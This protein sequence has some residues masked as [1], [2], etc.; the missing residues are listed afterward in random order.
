MIKIKKAKN[1]RIKKN[2]SAWY[3]ILTKMTMSGMIKKIKLK[4]AMKIL[5]LSKIQQSNALCTD[6]DLRL[7]NIYLK[8]Y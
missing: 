3:A 6:E 4:K 1:E 7:L 5:K 8:I 2:I